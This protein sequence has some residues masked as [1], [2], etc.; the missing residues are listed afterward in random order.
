[1]IETCQAEK[2]SAIP[3][4]LQRGV[5]PRSLRTSVGSQQRPLLTG[6]W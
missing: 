5:E 1:M 4:S 2:P 6:A 3:G